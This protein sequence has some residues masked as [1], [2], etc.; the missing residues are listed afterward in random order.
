MTQI[1]QVATQAVDDKSIK[2]P[3]W[4]KVPSGAPAA[5]RNAIKSAEQ[6]ASV[7]NYVKDQD[8]T[9][10]VARYAADLA[11]GKRVVVL[12]H[13]QG[14]F[15]ANSA[16]ERLSSK[17]GFGIVAVGTPASFTAGDGP[18][19]TLTNDQIITPI[20]G[21][22]AP[23]TTNGSA[24]VNATASTDGHSFTGNYL[25][26]DVSGPQIVAQVKA[27]IASLSCPVTP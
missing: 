2:V 26:G 25:N 11:A 10:H 22:R 20:P 4:V 3:S 1:L 16:Y 27:R 8:L 12:A 6:A 18:Y 17:S 24:F 7:E 9:A 13:S 5:V 21:R 14:N 15:Y 19:T 23:N